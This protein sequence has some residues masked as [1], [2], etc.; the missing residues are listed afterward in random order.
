VQ[1]HGAIFASVEAERNAFSPMGIQALVY[2]LESFLDE[3]CKWFFRWIYL[4]EAINL[5]CDGFAVHRSSFGRSVYGP[6]WSFVK[7]LD[8]VTDLMITNLNM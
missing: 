7:R 6:R 2:N 3:R 8:I 1:Q 4:G 5:F